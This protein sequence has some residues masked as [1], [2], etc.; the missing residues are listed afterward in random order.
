MSKL[1]GLNDITQCDDSCQPPHSVP[2]APEGQALMTLAPP[3][4]KEAQ[5]N[6]GEEGEG[7][8]EEEHGV[9]PRIEAMHF[10]N[11]SYFL[12]QRE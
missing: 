8:N 12:V 9:N 5:L 10:N 1:Q 11:T 4:Y 6:E 3:C 7:E 2:T